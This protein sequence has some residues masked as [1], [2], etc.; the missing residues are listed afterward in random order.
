MISLRE[1]R[2]EAASVVWD[3]RSRG[4]APAP[5]SLGA[6]RLKGF[7]RAFGVAGVGVLIYT[8]WSTAIATVVFGIASI[9]FLAVTLSPTGIYLGIQRLIAALGGITGVILTWSL[10]T[11]LFYLFFLP[12]G[13][14][15]R[16]GR[17]DR[18]RR[19][20]EPDADSYWEPHAG[21][22]A[23]SGSHDRQF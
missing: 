10:L 20:F 11:P 9:I 18:K 22:T 14:L 13:R 1:A 7:A 12:F 2:P 8:L 21:S 16:R 6:I 4:E 23:S 15:M 17:R 19:F 3:W 5:A